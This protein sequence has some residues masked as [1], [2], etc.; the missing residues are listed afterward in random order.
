MPNTV[1]HTERPKSLAPRLLLAACFAQPLF[2]FGEPLKL[3]QTPDQMR[4][5]MTDNDD[6]CPGCGVVTNVRRASAAN[7]GKE[8]GGNA[9]RP[10]AGDPGP[11]SGVQPVPIAGSGASSRAERR[12]AAQPTGGRWIV[13]VRYD[14]GSYAAFEQEDTPDVRA[15]E[16]IKVVSGRVEKR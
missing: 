8:S 11:G 1:R 16:R 3:P 13:T 2:A 7:P 15:G 14:N 12:K 9:A 10:Y 5:Y 4:E 6:R